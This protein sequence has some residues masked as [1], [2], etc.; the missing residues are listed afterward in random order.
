M[1]PEKSLKIYYEKSFSQPLSSKIN[2]E[3]KKKVKGKDVLQNIYIYKSNVI[4]IVSE[5]VRN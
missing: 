1:L 4:I 3:N 2:E 5:R